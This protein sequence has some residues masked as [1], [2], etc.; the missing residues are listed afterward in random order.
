M[1]F[2]QA[3]DSIDRNR[4]LSI[5]L[6]FN[7]HPKLVRLIEC[8]MRNIKCQVKIAGE[9]TDELDVTQGLKQGDGLATTLFNLAL[10]YAV[11]KTG[12]DVNATLMDRSAQIIEYA[13][14]LNILGRSVP[15]IREIFGNLEKAA[16]EIGLVVNEQK[17]KLMVQSKKRK[18]QIGQNITIGDYNFEVVDNF[19]YLGSNM[20]ADNEEA[21][22]ILKRIATSNR[23]F[24]SMLPIMKSRNIHRNV[25]LRLY[26]TLIR[27]VVC[28]GSES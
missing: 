2:K 17:T 6:D 28:Y 16:K 9:L 11:R 24:Y 8:T 10:E 3:Y 1:D 14:D 22:E 4:M 15:A 25:K 19:S 27:T 23:M 21:Q 13:D 26:K 5:L 18:N 7:I 12:V 20:T